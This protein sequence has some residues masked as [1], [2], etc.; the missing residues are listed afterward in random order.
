MSTAQ[1]L[2]NGKDNSPQ[3]GA[4]KDPL[5]TCLAAMSRCPRGL[6]HEYRYPALS[7]LPQSS[8]PEEAFALARVVATQDECNCVLVA[9]DLEA[10]G[11]PS[12]EA[13]V[14]ETGVGT[15]MRCVYACVCA[16]VPVCVHGCGYGCNWVSVGHDLE[17]PRQ[18]TQKTS[19]EAPAGGGMRLAGFMVA[20][21]EVRHYGC[22]A[23]CCDGT[24]ICS[25]SPSYKPT[26]G[27]HA[28][29]LGRKIGDPS[30]D[31]FVY[32]GRHD[33]SDGRV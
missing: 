27:G 5:S 11:Q 32:A 7:Q 16:C 3:G 24:K 2:S 15:R 23:A 9:H 25:K 8:R 12:Q 6:P 14:E 29:L 26:S 31:A 21:S 10:P 4:A 1:T 17:A 19:V 33:P 28:R 22:L 13:S 30:V 18:P 20:T